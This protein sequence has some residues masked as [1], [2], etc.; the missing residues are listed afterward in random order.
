MFVTHKPVLAVPP[1]GTPPNNEHIGAFST[2]AAPAVNAGI[3]AC[4]AGQKASRRSVSKATAKP[5]RGTTGPGEAF[6]LPLRRHHLPAPPLGPPLQWPAALLS[7][8]MMHKGE[9]GKLSHF[10]TA[11]FLIADA[12]SPNEI[13]V[14]IG[15]ADGGRPYARIAD[16]FQDIAEMAT[17]R[18]AQAQQ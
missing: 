12:P 3:R 15:A 8:P 1:G 11:N 9:S 10:L 4:R 7:L 13:V 2:A 17:E 5:G 6:N 18:A 16:R 14:A